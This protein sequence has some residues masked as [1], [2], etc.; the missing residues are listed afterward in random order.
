MSTRK[1][2]TNH[3]VEKLKHLRDEGMST[4]EIA[5]ILGRTKSSIEDMCHR[6]MRAGALAPITRI[7]KKKICQR[8][9]KRSDAERYCQ[10]CAP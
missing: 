3:E 7:Q 6:L 9:R 1:M 5:Q 2:W 10:V 8:A 4:Y